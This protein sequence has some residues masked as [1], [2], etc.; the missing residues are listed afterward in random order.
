MTFACSLKFSMKIVVAI[1]R[2]KFFSLCKHLN[3]FVKLI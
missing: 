3:Y 1:F 2:R